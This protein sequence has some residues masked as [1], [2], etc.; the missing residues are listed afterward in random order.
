MNNRV[1]SGTKGDQP[2]G[3]VATGT[4]VMDRALIPCPAALTTIAV[5][6]ED[7]VAMS[8]EPPAR[9]RRLP[10]AASAQSGDGRITAASAEQAWL[11][12]FQPGSV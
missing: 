3:G 1:A 4:A 10:V 8:A 9:V 7:R 5:A 11:G 6:G 2:G 12:R